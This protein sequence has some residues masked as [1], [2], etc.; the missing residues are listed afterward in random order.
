MFF[1]SFPTAFCLPIWGPISGSS[2]CNIRCR[3]CR[4]SRT[5]PTLPQDTSAALGSSLKQPGMPPTPATAWPEVK[6]DTSFLHTY[7]KQAT[8]GAAGGAVTLHNTTFSTS[9]PH[10]PVLL[11]PDASFGAERALH[12]IISSEELEVTAFAH[13]MFFNHVIVPQQLSSTS[14]VRL[15]SASTSE[16]A[17]R[18]RIP[19]TQITAVALCD[20]SHWCYLSFMR[21]VGEEIRIGELQIRAA[22]PAC[23][24]LFVTTATQRHYLLT[25]AW[26]QAWVTKRSNTWPSGQRQTQ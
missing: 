7:I 10:Q 24:M 9:C 16:P 5:V 22:C 15:T 12:E 6:K 14:C 13:S 2:D 20:T 19:A 8:W 26:M 3:S 21:P 17:H 23:W 11:T 18:L 4:K 25:L 1:P